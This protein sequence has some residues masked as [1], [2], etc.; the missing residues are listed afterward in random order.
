MQEPTI[1]HNTFVLERSYPVTP[2]RVFAALSDPAKKHRWFAEGSG[3]TDVEGFE[4][5]FRIGGRE[6]ARY[7]FKEGSPF[8]G[9][10]LTSDGIYHDIVP[11]RRVVIAATMA[12]GGKHISVALATFELLPTEKGT[13]LIFTH[14]AA[15]FEG[16]D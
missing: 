13:D 14:Q 6:Q 11:N 4:M 10:L 5:D 16:S 3:G 7:R 2:E 9:V 1:I 12:I 8:P 15:F